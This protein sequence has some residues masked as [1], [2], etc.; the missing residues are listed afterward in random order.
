MSFGF[1]CVPLGR[2][3]P[4]SPFLKAIVTSHISLRV[5]QERHEQIRSCLRV[6]LGVFSLFQAFAQFSSWLVVLLMYLGF[7]RSIYDCNALCLFV[8]SPSCQLKVNCTCSA[9]GL[10]CSI[11]SVALLS[12]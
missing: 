3:W 1:L 5:D 6:C 4:D 11:D 12:K 2:V 7:R 8:V 10:E 9:R